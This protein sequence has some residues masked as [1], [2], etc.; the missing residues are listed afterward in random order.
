[1]DIIQS[2]YAIGVISADFS[3]PLGG[4]ITSLSNVFGI[5]MNVVIGSVYA[6]GFI[7][8]SLGFVN[9]AMSQG[10]KYKV[11]AAKSYL[12]YGII[13][14]LIALF[15]SGARTF[16]V[17]IYTGTT[18]EIPTITDFITRTGGGGGG[19]D[20]DDGDLGDDI[21]DPPVGDDAC[22]DS[23]PVTTCGD[24]SIINS[25]CCTSSQTCVDSELPAYC[26]CSASSAT[27]SGEDWSICCGT[28]SPA[29]SFNASG[30]PNCVLNTAL[31]NCRRG[32]FNCRMSA[33]DPGVCCN[34]Y[35]QECQ[36]S[37]GTAVCVNLEH[38]INP[39]EPELPGVPIV[40]PPST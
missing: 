9:Y 23:D 6:F 3:D 40:P 13:A 11:Q 29:C 5:V 25:D 7:A 34:L 10:D 37:G 15:V 32:T 22:S 16:L 8:I 31:N 18:F 30:D 27:C 14:I 12:T 4:R 24:G 28:A 17:S 35:T 26:T 38:T 36:V 19:D 20:G 21:D 1:M 2:V 33:T 39:L